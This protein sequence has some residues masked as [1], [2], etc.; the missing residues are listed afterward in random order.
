M[1]E[2]YLMHFD[3]VN[4]QERHVSFSSTNVILNVLFSPVSTKQL[5]SFQLSKVVD[6]TKITDPCRPIFWHLFVGV[7]GIK[8]EMLNTLQPIDCKQAKTCFVGLL[9]HQLVSFC[10]YF[11]EN[12]T[13]QIPNTY[14]ASLSICGKVF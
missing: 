8:R 14:E 11:G 13:M 7:P 12:V 4:T 1:S 3:D 10:T 2:C 6:D 9:V 5:F